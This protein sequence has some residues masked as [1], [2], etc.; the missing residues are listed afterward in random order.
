MKSF[1]RVFESDLLLSLSIESINY[2]TLLSLS[3][4]T[5]V[6]IFTANQN[7]FANIMSY[8]SLCNKSESARDS[9]NPE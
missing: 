7:E 4:F 1:N 8:Y 9:M 3:V 2:F 5:R 6:F